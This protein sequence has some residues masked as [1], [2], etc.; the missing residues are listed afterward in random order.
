MLREA[1]LSSACAV[2]GL[3]LH[4]RNPL[5]TSKLRCCRHF[6]G[7]TLS[8]GKSPWWR[9]LL[10]HPEVACAFCRQV[11][12][13]QGQTEQIFCFFL[14]LL[15]WEHLLWR[16]DASGVCFLFLIDLT[17]ADVVCES[18]TGGGCPQVSLEL[19]A[20]ECFP[21][22]ERFKRR[23][24]L[25]SCRAEEKKGPLTLGGTW[26]GMAMNTSAQR[27]PSRANKWTTAKSW[28]TLSLRVHTEKPDTFSDK[29]R[30]VT[31]TNPLPRDTAL[32]AS[33]PA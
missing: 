32:H 10:S 16:A 23:Q 24:L 6:H 22:L 5:C 29:P 3:R 26:R 31:G 13:V 11:H 28:G 21:Y 27:E 19:S 2:F 4:H 20:V 25:Q 15:L 33:K 8:M 18:N 30:T 12:P 7:D 14:P 1:A 9:P 17:E